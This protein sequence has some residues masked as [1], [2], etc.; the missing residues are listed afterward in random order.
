M[1]EKVIHPINDYYFELCVY[2]PKG[3]MID[4]TIGCNLS[5]RQAKGLYVHIP[6]EPR[7]STPAKKE[8]KDTYTGESGTQ[9]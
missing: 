1:K 9:G 4:K 8:T 7:K 3:K 5:A 2:S 6:E